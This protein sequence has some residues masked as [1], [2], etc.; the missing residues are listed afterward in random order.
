MMSMHELFMVYT[1]SIHVFEKRSNLLKTQSWLKKKNLFP[2]FT[3]GMYHYTRLA[4]RF[5]FNNIMSYG[6]IYRTVYCFYGY[7]QKICLLSTL[8]AENYVPTCYCFLLKKIVI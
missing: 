2:S 1:I 7:A 8:D 6:V 3:R 5:N 4:Y